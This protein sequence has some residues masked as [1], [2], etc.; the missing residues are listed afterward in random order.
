MQFQTRELGVPPDFPD[1][2]AAGPRAHES[3]HLLHAEHLTHVARAFHLQKLL[4]EFI[5]VL[6]ASVVEYARDGFQLY[7][8]RRTTE[9]HFYQGLSQQT[10]KI[11]LPPRSLRRV[12]SLCERP[13]APFGRASLPRDAR[14]GSHAG[15][16]E[17]RLRRG[18]HETIVPWVLRARQRQT[19][20]ALA[21]AAREIA[22]TP[23]VHRS[24]RGPCEH[25][26]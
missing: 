26:I 19:L 13:P 21:R 20:S 10:V 7:R 18:I 6:L 23:L 15:D 4:Q 24:D 1:A 22:T 9:F 17:E 2:A 3:L 14:R 16:R 25:T 8:P 11:R 5:C 12:P